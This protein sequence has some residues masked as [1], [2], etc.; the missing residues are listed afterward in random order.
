MASKYYQ[1]IHKYIQEVFLKKIE[2]MVE[3]NPIS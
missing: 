2:L 3:S 1:L